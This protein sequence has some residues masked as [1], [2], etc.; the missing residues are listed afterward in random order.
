MR[1][2]NV[3]LNLA[4]YGGFNTFDPV[5][6][7]HAPGFKIVSSDP[8]DDSQLKVFKTTCSKMPHCGNILVSGGNV[9]A[10]LVCTSSYTVRGFTYIL[11]FVFYAGDYINSLR[12]WRDFANE[13]FLPGFFSGRMLW[14]WPP[15]S[16]GL[17]EESS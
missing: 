17:G 6:F 12:S 3:K 10:M 7:S 14:S 9:R 5:T 15:S 11:L 8:F 4:V 13:C 16:E 2:H 1:A